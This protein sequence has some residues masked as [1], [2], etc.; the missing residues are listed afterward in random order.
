MFG[1]KVL[2]VFVF[3]IG[4]I[5]M[6]IGFHW[7]SSYIFHR[8]F[9]VFLPKSA[10][11]RKRLKDANETIFKFCKVTNGDRESIPSS[12]ALL[13]SIGLVISM[14]SIVSFCSQW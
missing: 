2:C 11:D 1:I 3:I 9:R 13:V 10:K 5:L 7:Y 4:I 12:S 6:R 8:S 14:I